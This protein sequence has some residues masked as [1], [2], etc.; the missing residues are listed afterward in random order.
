MSIVLTVAQTKQTAPWVSS[1]QSIHWKTDLL[2]HLYHFLQWRLLWSCL[3]HRPPRLGSPPGW[4][5]RWAEAACTHGTPDPPLCP[6]LPCSAPKP[7]QTG[8]H[9]AADRRDRHS[10]SEI[11]G[12]TAVICYS[13][14]TR[15]SLPGLPWNKVLEISQKGLQ[16]NDMIQQTI[17]PESIRRRKVNQCQQMDS[18]W[19]LLFLSSPWQ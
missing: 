7:A 2:S 13:A 1:D 12:S 9:G 18:T 19:P 15:T 11:C 6:L 10:L 4:S 3:L 16:D 5:G 14:E 17:W 8:R